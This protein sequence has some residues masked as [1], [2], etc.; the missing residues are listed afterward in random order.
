M[1][2]LLRL[3]DI[4]GGYGKREVLHGISFTIQPGET[5]VLLGAN[6][7]GKSTLLKALA[8]LVS[9]SGKCELNGRD[10][11][12]L[13]P[14][15]R[16]RQIGYLTQRPEVTLALTS[17]EVVLM[18]YNP[19]L[20]LLER[21]GRKERENAR[22]LLAQ[23][24]IG[25]FAEA[26]YQTLSEGQRQLVLLARTLVCAPKLLLL[27]EPDSALDYTNRRKLLRQLR[28]YAREQGVGVLLCTHDAN[29]ALRYGDRL[30]CLQEGRLVGN[31]PMKSAEEGVLRRCL[32]QLYGD[33]EL[34]QHKGYFLMTGDD[35]V[36]S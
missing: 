1:A 14:R 10:L 3:E 34:L 5:G 19:M 2:E 30:L 12:S 16:A 35:S 24:G 25:D 32:S 28:Q 11:W 7:S 33:V 26:D 36:C 13:P 18:G 27:D 23:L 4:R 15:G 9:A 31:I 17:L 29:T 6:G 22:S 21:P 20:R 8:G